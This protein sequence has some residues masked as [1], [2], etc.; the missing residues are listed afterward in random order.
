MS[1]KLSALILVV[2]LPIL[3]F[4]AWFMSSRSFAI[5]LE[6]EKQRIIR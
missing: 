2:T 1:K 5:S 4:L 3:F 6:Q